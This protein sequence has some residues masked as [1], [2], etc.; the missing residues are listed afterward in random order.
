MVPQLPPAGGG[1]RDY[2]HGLGPPWSRLLPAAITQ[3]SCPS[4]PWHFRILSRFF[5]DVYTFDHR[6][7]FFL[8]FIKMYLFILIGG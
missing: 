7:F 6:G 3:F 2:S 8:H 1:D 4:E 5:I